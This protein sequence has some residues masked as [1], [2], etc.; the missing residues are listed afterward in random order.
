MKQTAGILLFTIIILGTMLFSACSTV[1]QEAIVEDDFFK[2]VDKIV[3]KRPNIGLSA[4]RGVSEEIIAMLREQNNQLNDVIRELNSLTKNELTDS[5]KSIEQVA[6]SVTPETRVTNEAIAGTIREQNIRLQGVQKRLKSLS[7]RRERNPLSSASAPPPMYDAS[8]GYGKAIQLYEQ[9]KFR[10]AI[11][12]FQTL[13]NDGIETDLQDNC[14]FWIGVCEFR[15]KRTRRA[16]QEFT[17]VLEIPNTDKTEN[18]YFMLGQCYEQIGSKKRAKAEF[19]KVLKNYPEGNLSQVVQ[20][21]L[22]LLK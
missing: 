16:I 3:F 1:T 21:K 7:Q 13:L 9:R 5:L 8:Q 15:L 12:E 18:A 17:K 14:H 10:S 2:P 6:D 4:S 19:E 11:K 22:A 20:I